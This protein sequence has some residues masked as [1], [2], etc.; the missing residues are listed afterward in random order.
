MSNTANLSPIEIAKLA[1]QA[2]DSK[3][4]KDI[5]GI[6]VLDITVV[7][8]YFVIAG[9]TSTTQTKALAAE[10]EFQLAQKGIK[11]FR[12][13]GYTNADWVVLDYGSVIV[14]VF[15]GENRNFYSLD[16]VWADGEKIDLL[17]ND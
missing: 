4:G 13:E 14:H 3:K 10:V 1:A 5:Q 2:L 8:D 7:T 17:E 9:A 11:P 16:R 12:T 6:K 15:N